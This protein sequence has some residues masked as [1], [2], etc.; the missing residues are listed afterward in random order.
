MFS[1]GSKIMKKIETLISAVLPYRS[2]SAVSLHRRITYLQ[3]HY[4]E[5]SVVDLDPF[6]IRIQELPGS[7]LDLHMQIL[8]KMAAKDA[9]CKIIN[10]PI[11]RLN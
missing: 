3:F 4:I 7:D 6:W 9:K 8:F 1:S 2:S 5:V 10:S 11:Q